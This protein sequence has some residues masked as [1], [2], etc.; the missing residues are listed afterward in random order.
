MSA[1]TA[2]STT[3]TVTPKKQPDCFK[4]R[5]QG[6]WNY[7]KV[8]G[9]VWNR[10][11]LTVSLNSIIGK[12]KTAQVIK[13]ARKQGLGICE[14]C[15]VEISTT[16]NTIAQL[17]TCVNRMSQ[18]K[19]GARTPE[20][21]KATKKTKS[22]SHNTEVKKKLQF[23]NEPITTSPLTTSSST[24]TSETSTNSITDF[25]VQHNPQYGAQCLNHTF[26]ISQQK[27]LVASLQTGSVVK[28]VYALCKI[29]N[30]LTIMKRLLLE[31]LHCQC[32]SLASLK[33]PSTL[34]KASV[35]MLKD[36]KLTLRCI[37]EMKQ[38]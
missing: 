2:P 28:F 11:D 35:E 3:A 30:V 1:D 5:Q 14:R 24:S 37:E 33:T 20:D 7:L 23:S 4:C 26:S 34:R 8:E 17:E 18:A 6:K 9:L 16:C 10:K 15:V 19:R 21:Q 22:K 31:D 27:C 29:P 38:R 12:E 36:G 32:T 25:G 13:A